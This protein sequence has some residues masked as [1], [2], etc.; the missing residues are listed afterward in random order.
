MNSGEGGRKGTQLISQ[1]ELRPLSSSA[2][3]LAAIA[4]HRVG[5][6]P[7]RNEPRA[8]KRRPKYKFLTKPR[9]SFPNRVPLKA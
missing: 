9:Q 5:D 1:K 8:N 4:T 7:H 3:L 6:R 2:A